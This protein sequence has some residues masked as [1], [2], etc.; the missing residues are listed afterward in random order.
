MSPATVRPGDAYTLQIALVNEGK[1]PIKVSGMT[2]TTTVNGSAQARPTAPRVKE[3]APQQRA[4]L[5]EV[6]GVWGAS[7]G[8]WQTE[9]L[10]TAGKGDSLKNQITWK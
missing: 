3:I 2:V 5:E 1:K 7:V 9:V 10:V 6:P 8:S 4:V